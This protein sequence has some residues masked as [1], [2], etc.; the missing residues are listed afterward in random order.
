MELR[1][2]RTLGQARVCV[3]KRAPLHSSGPLLSVGQLAKGRPQAS[4]PASSPQASNQSFSGAQV[5][6]LQAAGR[7]LFAV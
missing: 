1:A 5:A 6:V 4:Q 3:L 2:R 7:F